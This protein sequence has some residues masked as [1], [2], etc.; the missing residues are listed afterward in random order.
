VTALLSFDVSVWTTCPAMAKT[1]SF[2]AGILTSVLIAM[3]DIFA[4]SHGFGVS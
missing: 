3:P 2:Y 4:W 1:A